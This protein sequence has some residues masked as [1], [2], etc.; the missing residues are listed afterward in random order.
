MRYLNART[1][2]AVSPQS[3][4]PRARPRPLFAVLQMGA[5]AVLLD[6]RRRELNHLSDRVLKD[7]GLS[8]GEI[9]GITLYA[10]DG[11]ADGSRRRRAA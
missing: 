11:R 1:I 8:R 4:L 6:S 7:I 2:T 3:I 9:D 5:A 10:I